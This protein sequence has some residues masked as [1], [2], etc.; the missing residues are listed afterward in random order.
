MVLLG[1]QHHGDGATFQAKTRLVKYLHEQKGFNVLVWE[2]DVYT[3]DDVA[4][5]NLRAA[6]MACNCPSEL[7]AGVQRAARGYP[8]GAGG[9]HAPEPGPPRQL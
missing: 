8:P 6:Q 7:R 5:D 2:S 3:E 4:A 9:A 1:E